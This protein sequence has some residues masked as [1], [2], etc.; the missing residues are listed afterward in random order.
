MSCRLV[1]L[2]LVSI[3]APVVAQPL[4]PTETAVTE[5]AEA[6]AR[7][8][9]YR[10]YGDGGTLG[11]LLR[12]P[13]EPELLVCVSQDAFETAVPH[14]TLFLGA[15]HPS[16]GSARLPKDDAEVERVVSLLREATAESFSAEEIDAVLDR[17]HWPEDRWERDAAAS[18]L[19]VLKRL[20]AKDSH[21]VYDPPGG[22]PPAWYAAYDEDRQRRLAKARREAEIDRQ[23]L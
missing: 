13:D 8:V 19:T 5:A 4:P 15:W 22:E 23:F 14:N 10:A 16:D 21:D 11:L 7:V 6:N 18:A 3:G 17:G 1:L 9:D 12:R 20:R 2:L